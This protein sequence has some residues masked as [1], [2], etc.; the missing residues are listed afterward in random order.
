M[1]NCALCK[2]VLPD[3]MGN[4][5]AKKVYFES[6]EYLVCKPCQKKYPDEMDIIKQLEGLLSDAQKTKELDATRREE[7]LSGFI[8]TTTSQI[9][10]K[11]IEKYLGIVGSQTMEGINIF[12]DLFGALRNVVG[13]RSTALQ[14][15]MKTM[16]STALEE[17]TEEALNIGANAVVGI[18]IDFDEYSEGMIMLSISGTAVIVK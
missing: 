11:I 15:A 13:G 17:L 18:K 16:R 2:D 4:P 9:E 8:L 14:D 10:G 3:Y 1:E 5:I 6:K 7:R 12:K